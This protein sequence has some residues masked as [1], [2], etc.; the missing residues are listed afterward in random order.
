[1]PQTDI[2]SN[3]KNT[4]YGFPRAERLEA[5]KTAAAAATG[6]THRVTLQSQV[7]DFPI[8]KVRINVPKYRMENG[9]T[10]SAQV[11][12]LAKH[13]DARKD[14]F[15]GDP[16]LLDAQEGQHQLL[17]KLADKS[18]LRK[19]FENTTYKQVD[20]ILLDHNG[21]VINGNRRLAT[22]RDLF[23]NGGSEYK[24]FEY[25]DVVVLPKVDDKAIDRLEAELQIEQDIKADYSWDAEANMMLAKQQRENYTNKDLGELYGKKEADV[26]ELL[27]MR[28]YASEWLSSRGKESMWSIVAGS[29]LAFR[30]IVTTRAK[31]GG[32][33]RQDLFK[34]A[35]F[36]LIDNP[37]EVND[38]LHDAINN[39]GN[40]I[41]VIV[42]KL[43]KAFNVQAPVANAALDDMFG[44]GGAQNPSE[45]LDLAIAKEIE[46]E[47]KAAEARKIIVDLIES[48][49]L[50]RR[51][52]KS[53]SK[54][55]DS[56]A[57]ANSA[58]QEACMSL[59]PEA[60]VDGVEAQ[61][62]TL[63]KNIKAIRAFLAKK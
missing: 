53:A 49:K 11:E 41:G 42:D 31:V 63:E 16:E 28:D 1:M 23:Q 38:S 20:P 36:A 60:K 27:D 35:A 59:T 25:I 61:L 18:D 32:P 29:E 50:K 7:R 48:E 15:S 19:K 14:L 3:P 58:L 45:A 10:S 55:L 57:K 47:D 46:N 5:F 6:A 24:H 37:A 9:R 13:K 62:L 17:L 34:K 33:G 4:L 2:P 39:L 40:H 8:I 43:Q 51:E 30:R 21:F 44:G 12:Y 22:W 56:C 52:N 54:L 26:T